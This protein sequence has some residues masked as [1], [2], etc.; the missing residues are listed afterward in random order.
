LELLDVLDPD[1]LSPREALE[2][3]EALEAVCQLKQTRLRDIWE[4]V[5]NLSQG[6]SVCREP[7]S[8]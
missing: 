5:Q 3:L 8:S 7:P 1:A 2:A 4:P 6:T